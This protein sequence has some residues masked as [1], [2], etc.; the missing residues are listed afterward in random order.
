MPLTTGFVLTNR[1]R[2]VSLLGQGSFGTVYRTLG[3]VNTYTLYPPWAPGQ[4]GGSGLPPIN[5]GEP[6]EKR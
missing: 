2:V 6:V 4:A 5:V 1:Y 3:D